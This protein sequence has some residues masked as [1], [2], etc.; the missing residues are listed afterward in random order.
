MV[1]CKTGQ[2][3]VGCETVIA[4]N[5]P[6]TNIIKE[7]A[8]RVEVFDRKRIVFVV[9]ALA[10]AGRGA[11]PCG[12]QHAN[13]IGRVLRQVLAGLSTALASD[14]VQSHQPRCSQLLGRRVFQQVAS[15]LLSSELVE[16]FV[17][18]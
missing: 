15:Q 18:V 17:V 16:R 11:K 6:L 5:A 8:E 9:V 13:A 4:V 3:W 12:S 14:H 2:V 1:V 7:R 10:A